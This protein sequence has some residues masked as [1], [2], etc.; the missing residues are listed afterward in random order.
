MLPRKNDAG[1]AAR[2]RL[3]DASSPKA[4]GGS[5]RTK[6]RA[7]PDV[8]PLV[9]QTRAFRPFSA[10]S[11]RPSWRCPVLNGELQ[12]ARVQQVQQ[13]REAEELFSLVLGVKSKN[14]V[15]SG[16]LIGR[17]GSWLGRSSGL[18]LGVPCFYLAVM[19]AAGGSILRE[20]NWVGDGGVKVMGRGDGS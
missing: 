16:S 12:R 7:L 1:A 10:V 18:F 4:T 11:A 9:R 15:R 8:S 5:C 19:R 14:V 2:V 3:T 13:C 17:G 6:K 20:G